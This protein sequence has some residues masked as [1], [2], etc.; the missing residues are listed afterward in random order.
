VPSVTAYETGNTNE[1]T[2][3][4]V[5]NRFLVFIL[6]VHKRIPLMAFTHDDE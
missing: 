6:N 4:K 5:K 1:A 3:I 2:A